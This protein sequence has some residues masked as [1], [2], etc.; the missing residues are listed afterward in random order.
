MQ[1]ITFALG[2]GRIDCHDLDDTK[3]KKVKARMMLVR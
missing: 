3:P 1:N 2:V